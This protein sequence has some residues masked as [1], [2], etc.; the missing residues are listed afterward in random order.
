V[1]VQELAFR[2]DLN[3]MYVDHHGWLVGWLRRKLNGADQAFDL[4][5]DTFLR[6][7]CQPEHK[8]QAPQEPRAI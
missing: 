2:K 6:I 4:A 7:V 3:S 8:R 1:S 5:Q